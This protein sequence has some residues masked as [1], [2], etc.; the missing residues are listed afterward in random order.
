MNT[1]KSPNL[2]STL[3]LYGAAMLFTASNA[4]AG[5]IFGIGNPG[6]AGTD[7]VLF[8]DSNLVH[9][10]TLVQGNFAG[11]GAGFIIDF[12]SASGNLQIQGG[13]G[14]ATIS[15]LEG[16]NPF[17]H[18]KFEL[19][20]GAT[21]TKAILN[22]DATADGTINFTV[23]H[24]NAMGVTASTSFI[25]GNGSNFYNITSTDGTLIK[26]IAFST[27]DTLFIDASQF[28]IGGFT[29]GETAVPDGGT[30]MLM[31]GAALGGLA[32]LRRKLFR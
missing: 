31:L 1:G 8:N 29:A 23:T 25:G 6:N 7:N 2:I 24:I 26:S 4:T 11:E 27:N 14:Q 18:L 17:T 10:G 13:G 5:I 9:S 19:E 28:R 22:P 16:N 3:C 20:S 32:F 21:F 12:T 15:G 30:T